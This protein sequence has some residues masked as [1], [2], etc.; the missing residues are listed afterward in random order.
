MVLTDQGPTMYQDHLI[1]M[2]AYNLDSCGLSQEGH[3]KGESF[4]CPCSRCEDDIFLPFQ[5]CIDDI[6]LPKTRS[7]PKDLCGQYPK[8]LQ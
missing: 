6:E 7:L 1:G 5:D 3:P 4:A 8:L 2:S